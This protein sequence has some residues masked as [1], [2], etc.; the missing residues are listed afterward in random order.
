MNVIFC[1]GGTAG[2]VSPALAIAEELKKR[3]PDTNIAFIGREGG[4]ENEIIRKSGYKLY[5][6]KISGLIRRLTFKNFKVL[7]DAVR[8]EHKAED[9][10]T[11]FK[12]DAVIGTGGYVCLPVLRAASKL[13]IF[14]AIHE[15]NSTLGLSAKLIARRCDYLFLGAKQSSKRK[16]AIYVGNPVREEFFK[17]SKSE[18]RALLR[19][20]NGKFFIL[21]VGGS[22]GAEALNTAAMEM[23]RD[24]SQKNDG[25]IHYHSTGKRYFELVKASYPALFKKN[26]GCTVFPYIDKMS[27][28][29]SA[30]DIVI[31]RCGAMT[32][33]EIA[34]TGTPSILIP[35]PN[36]TANHQTKNAVYFVE[37]GASVLI[38]E[39]ELSSSLLTK[40]VAKLMNDSDRRKK[41]SEAAERLCTKNS[42]ERMVKIIEKHAESAQ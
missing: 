28:Y 30:A 6:I 15:S 7:K 20:P 9:I 2:H 22:I 32:L 27:L 4:S 25:I 12:A 36:V 8:A 3:R 26:E 5:E 40:I 33:S 13:G 14:T 42:A 1:G 18:A 39:S 19:I 11:R 10:L 23:M 29:L 16:N 31:S 38:N 21:S 17:T 37:N 35:S 24:F 34:A 41:M